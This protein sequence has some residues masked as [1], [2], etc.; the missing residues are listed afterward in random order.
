MDDSNFNFEVGR[1]RERERDEGQRYSVKCNVR[2]I[3]WEFR[4]NDWEE[5]FTEKGSGST[6]RGKLIYGENYNLGS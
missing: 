4:A 3:P 5:S 1:E 6:I 2:L